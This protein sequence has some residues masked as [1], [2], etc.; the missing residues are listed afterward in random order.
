MKTSGRRLLI[1]SCSKSKSPD[2]K[3]LPAIERY[4]G[5]TYKVLRKFLRERLNASIDI[6]ILSAKFGLIPS[7]RSIPYYDLEM[8]EKRAKKISASIVKNIIKVAAV[9]NYDEAFILLGKT[10]L[11]A[12]KGIEEVLHI[13]IH[14]SEMSSVGGYLSALRK[15][16]YGNQSRFRFEL[17]TTKNV[18][19]KGKKIIF[20]CD[21]VLDIAR[22]NLVH[23]LSQA[24]RFQGW[25][26]K[27]DQEHISPKWLV[28]KLTNLPLK[29]FHTH[30]AIQVLSKLGLEVNQT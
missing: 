1:L 16:L 5:P 24:R 4:Q 14:V 26:V 25:Y 19:I 23:E 7:S 18:T 8:T 11:H 10:Y 17:G 27:I 9:Q 28:S 22:A 2:R 15:W 12:V 13:P 21:E 29:S 30:Q 6:Y 3:L 20:T